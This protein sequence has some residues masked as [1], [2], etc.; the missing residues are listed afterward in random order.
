M[1]VPR[2]GGTYEV[3]AGASD[4]PVTVRLGVGSMPTAETRIEPGGWRRLTVEL[5]DVEGA[6]QRLNIDVDVP[7][8]FVG[9][10]GSELVVARQP[11]VRPPD[12]L[13]ISLDT[14]RRD[15]LTPYAPKL[16][17]TP[18]LAAFAKEAMRFDQAISTSSWTI[19]SHSTLFT[20]RYPADSLG[21][22]SRVEPGEYT[23]PEIFAADG[24]RTLG[25]SGG[26][27]TDPRWGL[28][29]GFDE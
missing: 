18:T 23:L 17:T 16:N 12:V 20:G 7:A 13:L 9:P 5:N 1:A 28:H 19:A 4:A 24:Y 26:P 6:I 25:V 22:K 15:Q 8:G 14:V 27:F 3:F 29:Q 10:W 21:Y 11:Q 2:S